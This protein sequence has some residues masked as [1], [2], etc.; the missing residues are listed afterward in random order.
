MFKLYKHTIDYNLLQVRE[1]KQCSNNLVCVFLGQVGNAPTG[2]L[3]V[4]FEFLAV[5]CKQKQI[6]LA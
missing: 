6:T 4:N 1:F 3:I 2:L 5:L